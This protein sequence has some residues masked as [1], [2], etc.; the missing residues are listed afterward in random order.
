MLSKVE[1]LKAERPPLEIIKDIYREASGGEKIDQQHIDL[2]KWYGMYPHANKD[3]K[4][5]KAYFMKRVKLIDGRMDKKALSI[6]SDIGLKYAQG[7][8]DFTTRQNIQF[9]YI[10]IKDLP[11]MFKLFEDTAL[12]SRLASGDGP[13]PIVNCPVS[14]LDKDDIID[15]NPIIRDLDKFFDENSEDFSNLPRKYKL[16]ISG[17]KCHCMGH[18]IQD[19]GF[20]AFK[21]G[22]E[23]LFDLSVGGGL[24]KTK[25]I[26]SR[27]NRYV[28]P[29]Q[30]KA[31]S[32]AG[33][34]LFREFGNRENRS[35]ARVRNLVEDWGVEKFV[36]E[37]EKKLGFGLLEGNNEP[38][39][40]PYAQREHF[41]IHDSI[42]AGESYI[43]CATNRGRVGG[44]QFKALSDLI[45][46][47]DAGGIALTTTQN[48]IVYGIK[49]EILEEFLKGLK[50]IGFNSNPSRF[51]ARTQ[52]CTGLGFCKFA[53]TETK[54]FTSSLI[55][56]LE[57]KFPNFDEHI[58]IAVSG[59][60]NGC[61][62]PHI[63]DIGLIGTKV[64]TD[65]GRV[66]GYEVYLG[67]TLHGQNGSKFGEKQVE[68]IPIT[69]IFTY[70]ENLIQARINK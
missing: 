1:A 59:C 8:I 68:K 58:A 32:I 62:H 34:E 16:G 64:K 56:H 35:K 31:V 3:G 15:V 57:E 24:A 6:M 46:K 38:E 22:E 65:E 52:S 51:E 70:V 63:A 36:E 29:D 53:I 47:Y 18:E 9:H 27:A 67:G 37:L 10:Q 42:V 20:T 13:R 14:G 26:A 12:T 44:E 45:N 40:T 5:D 2:L 60:P 19:I 28:K 43:G 4:E 55:A 7:Y 66:D 39:I 33:A 30:V 11:A 17:C 23:V 61:S 49:N 50:E 48:F 21:N 25:R 69:E 41:G 54:N